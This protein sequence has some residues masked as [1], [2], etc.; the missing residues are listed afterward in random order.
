MRFDLLLQRLA[1]KANRWEDNGLCTR[2]R[3]R[4]KIKTLADMKALG[5]E[6]AGHNG[7]VRYQVNGSWKSH[8]EIAQMVDSQLTRLAIVAYPPNKEPDGFNDFFMN[9]ILTNHRH[10]PDIPGQFYMAV[11][12]SPQAPAHMQEASIQRAKEVAES[13]TRLVRWWQA[14][15]P[16]PVV[17]TITKSTAQQ[18]AHDVKIRWQT[19]GLSLLVSAPVALGS[20]YLTVILTAKPTP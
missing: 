18:R 17:D 6:L 11:N 9:V 20:A 4:V 16:Y 3:K 15:A 13:C 14:L 1:D 19:A 7:A 2:Y 8:D 12:Y 10:A 5:E